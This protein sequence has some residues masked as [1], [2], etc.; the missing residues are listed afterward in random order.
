MEK[1]NQDLQQKME[2]VFQGTDEQLRDRYKNHQRTV[3]EKEKRLSD[4]KREL[5]RA[6]KECQ[7][8]NNEKSELLIER[9]RLQL[10]ADR[11]QE[12]I[13]VRDSLIQS[14]SAQLELDGF[15]Q[16]PF[17]DRQIAVFHELLKERQKSDTEAANQLMREFTQKEAMKQKQ[18]D[19]IRDRKTGLERTIDLKSDIQN[20]RQ[21]ELK[22]VKYEL[23]Q[24]EGSSDRI[25][26]LDQEIIKT[27]HELEKAERNSNVETLEQ[28]VQTLQNEKINLDKVLRRLDQE[29]E[30]LNLHTTTITQMEMLKKDKADKEEQIRKVKLR[31]SE[32]LTLLLGYFPNK[33]QLEDWLHGKSTE[34][35][36]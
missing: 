15:E 28:E 16:A 24:L 25:V 1:D 31:H 29:M 4:C 12:H 36:G 18:I 8:F 5:D 34:N 2:K 13:K 21:A 6:S 3:K 11:H 30:Q 20:K 32:E 7:R 33:K 10:Q 27:E 23:R 19:E 17:N 26:E 9:G 22:N 14:L 35:T